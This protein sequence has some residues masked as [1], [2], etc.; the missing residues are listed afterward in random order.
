MIEKG[1]WTAI[2]LAGNRPR[3]TDFAHALGFP[4][5]ALIEI[6]GEPMLGRVVKALLASPSVGKVVIMAQQPDSLLEG[7]LG[8]MKA[9]PRIG[10]AASGDGI[11]HSILAVAGSEAVPW[12]VLVTTADHA[13]LTPGMVECFVPNAAGSDA[14]VAVVE[15]EVVEAAYPETRRTWLKL[16]GG[17]YSGANLFALRTPASRKAIEIWSNVEKDRKKALKLFRFFGPLLALRAATRTISLDSALRTAA[18]RIG[19]TVAAV[20]LPFAEAAIDVDKPSDLEL[21]QRIVAGQQMERP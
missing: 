10:L 11:S 14:A 3:E 9:E 7:A 12:P 8:W 13:L 19:I 15:R 16:S 5:K 4:A 1:N 2:V 20:R 21:V 6:G 18:G 17:A